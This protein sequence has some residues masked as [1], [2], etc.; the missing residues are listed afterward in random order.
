ML[1]FLRVA[2]GFGLAVEERD[3]PTLRSHPIVMAGSPR[4]R[5]TVSEVNVLAA[6]SGIRPGMALP[7]VRQLCPDCLVL[8]AN[9]TQYEALWEELCE[10]LRAFTPLVEPIERGQVICDLAGCERLWGDP[11]ALACVIGGR[12]RRE[13]GIVPNLGLG[14]SRIVAEFAATAAGAGRLTV[15]ESGGTRTFLAGLP[16]SSLPNL[17]PRLAL[18]L[19]VL[20][21]RTLGQFAALPATAVG[22]RF[23][24]TGQ[25]LHRYARGIDPR[26]VVPPAPRPAV[27]ARLACEPDSTEEALATLLEVAERCAAE[28]RE[29]GLAGRLITLR[30]D[31]E[32][33][34]P[35]LLPSGAPWPSVPVSWVGG[36]AG[37]EG[38]DA[39]LGKEPALQRP[40][41][42]IS[43]RIHSMLPQPGTRS[44]GQDQLGS[45]EIGV[46]P[47]ARDPQPQEGRAACSVPSPPGSGTPCECPSLWQPALSGRGKEEHVTIDASGAVAPRRGRLLASVRTPINEVEALFEQAKRLLMEGWREG[48][49]LREIELEVAEF[50]GPR[51]MALDGMETGEMGGHITTRRQVLSE[52]ESL[53][54]SRHGTEPFRH[55]ARID[56]GG[57][58]TE[59]RVQWRAGLPW[60]DA[61]PRKRSGRKRR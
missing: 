59:R 26:P 41:F 42:P 19:H 58:L 16:V 48:M 22:S 52:G 3:R 14:P 44:S 12:V 47:R 56:P 33:E 39:P 8:A 20:G 4:E 37:T 25:I 1:L 53:L 60:R 9:P 10:I 29:R 6:R 34:M 31:W 21:I 7:Q 38:L 28:L 18:T 27:S 46:Q 30:L 54:A 15:V 36:E 13:I 5:A 49:Q 51:Q 35:R 55:V 45:D 17:D 50:E 40:D 57:V 2:P 61:P 32:D 24:P 23:G 43:Y 11:S